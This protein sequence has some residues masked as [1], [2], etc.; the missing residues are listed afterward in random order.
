LRNAPDFSQTVGQDLLVRCRTLLSRQRRLG[1][2]VARLERA[3][4][5]LGEAG[6]AVAELRQ[7]V[8]L[9]VYRIAP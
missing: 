7:L 2:L 6:A 3:E 9:G 4:R 8:G 1:D 5:A